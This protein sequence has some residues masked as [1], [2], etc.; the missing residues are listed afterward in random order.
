MK[1]VLY[2]TR[3]GLMEPLGHSQVLAYLRGLARDYRIILISYEKQEDSAD[4]ARMQALREEC[5]ALGIVWLPQSFVPKPKIIAP[6]FSMIRMVWLARREVRRNGAELIHARSYIPAAVAWLAG[7][8]TGVPFIFDMRALWPEELITAGRLRRGGLLHKAMVAAERACLGSSA[9][10]VSL[11]HAAVGHL[12]KI[13]PEEMAGQRVSVIPTCADLERFVPPSAPPA[14][15]RLHGCIGTVLSGWFHIDWL[16]SWIT[17]AAGRDPEA[18]FEILTRDDAGQV[19]AALALTPDVEARLSIGSRRPGEVAEAIQSHSLSVMFFTQGLSKLGSSPTRMGEVLGTGM[20]V[21]ANGGVG[22]V[23]QIIE[24][25][26]VGV[27]V[28][29]NTPEA[30]AAAY[31][32]LMV[33]MEDPDLPARCVKAAHDIFSLEAGTKAYRALYADILGESADTASV[34]AA[35]G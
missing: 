14:G 13:Y 25:N 24:D 4:T 15:P 30:M 6:L 26:R 3:N 17:E 2:L 27:L 32:T 1:T 23:A 8:M 31:D 16:A 35:A 20:P 11:T 10:V 34:E 18:R 28:S 19:R 29:E 22:D 5:A 9:G 21:V 12:R 33:L 7:K